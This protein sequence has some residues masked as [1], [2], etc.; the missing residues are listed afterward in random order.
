[1]TYGTVYDARGFCTLCN[2]RAYKVAE[3]LDYA[4]SLLDFVEYFYNFLEFEIQSAVN[5]HD[6]NGLYA[7]FVLNFFNQHC[8][9]HVLPKCTAQSVVYCILFCALDEL[10]NRG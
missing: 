9:E 3:H 4:I 7:C 6:G 5:V 1:M 8:S 2:F 10:Y